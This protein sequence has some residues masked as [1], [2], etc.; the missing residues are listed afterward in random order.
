MTRR[1]LSHALTVLI[2][3][4]SLAFCCQGAETFRFSDIELLRQPPGVQLSALEAATSDGWQP[5]ETNSPNLGYTH[6]TAWFRFDIPT[7]RQIDLLEI[8]YPHLD[9]IGF[10]IVKNGELTD[11]IITGDLN[12]FAQ[13]PV[14][15]RH[16]LFPFSPEAGSGG[17][18]LLEV[19]TEGTLQVPITLWNTQAF[20]EHASVEEQIHAAYYGILISVIF[21]N[22]FVFFALREKV[23]LLYVLSTLSYLL[24]IGN[25]NGTTFQ[26]IWPRSP[27]LN[28]HTTLIAV[29]LAITFT[30]LFASAFLSLKKT[31]PFLNRIIHGFVFLNVV[32]IFIGSFAAYS[33]AIRLT[34]AV[35]LPSTL[36]LTVI[37][38]M[39]WV[40]GKPQAGYYTIAWG[41]L[42][43][44]AAI[45]G[46]STYGVFP[47][48]FIT[49]YSMQLGSVVEATLIAL[50]LAARL[51]KE[52]EDKVE[53]R[54]SRIS[55]LE[56]K[57][58]A[59]LKLIE[60]ALHNPLTGLPNRAS[61]EMQV[62]DFIRQA[63]DKRH[64]IVVIH[65]N[66]LQSVTKTLGHQ[67]SDRILEL[68]ARRLNAITRDL[69]GIIS[70]GQHNGRKFFVASLDSET[71]AC[72]VDASIAESERTSIS[73]AVEA[74]RSPIDYLGMQVPLNT[75]LGVAISPAHGDD[76]TS[77]IRRA[78]IAEGS[79]RARELGIAYYK[80]SRD[81]YSAERLTMISELQ[82]A[83][84]NDELKLYLQPKLN[85]RTDRFDSLEALIR[86]PERE[87]SFP[88]D[89]I[90]MLAEQ[91]GV[92]KP[93][94]RWVLKQSLQIR[95]QLSERGHHLDISV[96]IS[97]YNLREP[98]FPSFVRQL[99]NAH[100]QHEGSIVFEVTETSMMQD[101]ANA[102][103]ALNSLVNAGIPV[104][105][106]DFGSGYSSL[107]YIKQL[108]ASEIKIDRSLITDLATREEDRVI[109]QTTIDMC[110][111]LGY[112]VVAEGVEDEATLN[113]LKEMGCDMIQGYLLSCPL[114]LEQILSLLS[115]NP[116]TI[117]VQH[118]PDNVHY[119][120]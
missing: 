119:Q 27:A 76:A 12:P 53:A 97:P 62:C 64:G 104:S 108:P 96:N 56:A 111:A 5:L 112:R 37:G 40:R 26:L 55:A 116:E 73:S 66:N 44:G 86:W 43:L 22:L 54:E 95:G 83:L 71:F 93:L 98:D 113:L 31:E 13:R 2:L 84:A 42:S 9:Y 19:R 33:D 103:K 45:T 79:D 34:I 91:S 49:T 100:P 20:F 60:N 115:G 25:L 6:D 47:H 120:R 35:A 50:A 67:N 23:Y 68:A 82:Q 110:H 80:T 46:A 11:R 51:Y 117:A 1:P 52:R 7:D 4:I 14:L 3:L 99:M 63:P 36:L 90:I 16:F 30:L 81:S 18:I 92:I 15:N 69:P 85:L 39:Q 8:A 32:T 24:L 58:S 61:F 89:E 70:L 94:T 105:I 107:S 102:L 59:E 48:N 41:A 88:T 38:P 77:L 75:Q 17:Q 87:P 29:P 10:Y 101:P 57:R 72:V 74:I 106:D 109:V 65:L 118:A 28:S 114:P 78:V 21:F